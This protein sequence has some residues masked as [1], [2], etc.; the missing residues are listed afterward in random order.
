MNETILI[1]ANEMKE[2]FLSILLQHGFEK[3]RAEICA[4]VFTSNS[5]DGV[6]THGVNRFYPF[7]LSVKNGFTIPNNEP[8]LTHAT[9]ALEQ[10]DGSLA[11]G[12]INAIKATDRAMQLAK[13]NGIGCAAL[14][15]TN[16]WMRGG[17]YGWQAAKAGYVLIA[18]TNTI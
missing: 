10:W 6:Y 11:P 3:E 15:H 16:H 18:W 7:I 5:I 1:P 2:T 8:T 9:A 17:Y 12:I 14:A 13:T 4:E